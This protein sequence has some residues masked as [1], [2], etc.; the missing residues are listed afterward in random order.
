M[1][2]NDLDVWPQCPYNRVEFFKTAMPMAIE[3]L[4]IAQH[5]DTLLYICICSGAYQPQL[6]RFSEGDYVYM[7]CEVPTILDVNVGY[8]ILRVKDVLPSGILL[9]KGKDGRECRTFKELCSM[10][11]SYR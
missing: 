1:D 5:G 8:T 7:Q 4:S 9:L 2:L 6:P 3:N 11:S 10:S